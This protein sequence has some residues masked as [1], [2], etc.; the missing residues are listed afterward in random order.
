M[1]TKTENRSKY[2]KFEAVEINRKQIKGAP[3]NPRKIDQAARNLLKRNLKK[4]G[5]LE[6]LVWNTKT[7]NLVSG[8]QRLSILDDLEGRD[9]YDLTVSKV[10]LSE[11]EEKEQNIFFNNPNAQGEFDMDMMVPLIDGID[12]KEAGFSDNDLNA[13]G[14][15]ID[16]ENYEEED[17]ERVISDFEEVKKDVKEKK[18]LEKEANPDS[19]NWKDVKEEIKKGI[20][21]KSDERENY[22]VVTFD[23]ATRKEAFL[24]RFELDQGNRYVKGEILTNIINK[25]LG[26]D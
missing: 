5:L 26:D 20:D 15:E 7:G 13:L 22:F 3:Y 18:R 23:N 21:E 14:I 8:H 6:T 10:N 1:T 2:Q 12:T 4:R 25:H 11:Q 24:K 9:D 16:L 17:V 19:K